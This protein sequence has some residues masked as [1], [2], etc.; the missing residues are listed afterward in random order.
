MNISTG[1]PHILLFERDQQLATL[2][3]SELQL[4]GYSC[5]TARTAVEVFDAIARHSI[6]LVLV[7]LAQAATARREFWVALDAQRRDHKVQVLTFL[8]ANLASYGPRDV[9]D[10]PQNTMADIEIDGMAGVMQMVDAIRSRVPSGSSETGLSTM[11]RV[12]KIATT[13]PT[14]T[15]SY[16]AA[17]S[18]PPSTPSS[19]TRNEGG[20]LHT[21]FYSDQN[22]HIIPS[23]SALSAL[24]Q[25]PTNT[26]SIPVQPATTNP[27]HIEP[28]PIQSPATGMGLT[29]EESYSEKIRAVLNP[30]QRSAGQ[31]SLGENSYVTQQ[32]YQETQSSNTTPSM[33]APSDSALQQLANGQFRTDTSNESGL[34]QLSRMLQ[35]FRAPAH[36]EPP[37]TPPPSPVP[38]MPAPIPTTPTTVTPEPTINTHSHNNKPTTSGNIDYQI[39]DPLPPTADKFAQP[40]P[41]D[42]LP[43]SLPYEETRSSSPVHTII[44]REEHL[45][46][47]D[48]PSHTDQLQQPSGPI[49]A[50]IPSSPRTTY[51]NL[52]EPAGVQP[53]RASP[54]QDMPIER[55]PASHTQ[56][57]G[58]RRSSV[59]THLH[60]SQ[61]SNTPSQVTTNPTPLASIASPMPPTTAAPAQT[62]TQTP[63]AQTP[64]TP[65]QTA[66]QSQPAEVNTQLQSEE[67]KGM[68]KTVLEKKAE[69]ELNSKK[70]NPAPSP[71]Q[72][73]KQ[74]QQPENW[75]QE[76]QRTSIEE[77]MS[78]NSAMLLDIVQSLPP[79]PELSA[80][81]QG[82]QP[83][84]LNGRAT[85][86]LNQ[87]LLD[88]HL[89]P[90]DRLEVAQNIQRMLRG[91]DLNY[92]LGEILL[93]FK[94]LTPDQ[95][96]A[97]GLVSYGLINTTQIS[98]LGRIRQ[99]LHALGLEYDLE[100]LLILFRILTPEQLRE[101]R[102]SMQS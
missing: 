57:D 93:M 64:A 86:S 33:P 22:A 99:E 24:S 6:R 63:P 29:E 14:N 23:K 75:S 18:T 17:P 88:G 82:V 96:L 41:F 65:K 90:Q 68:L 4:A 70:E 38:T 1:G 59:Q 34:A 67:L 101:V 12:P 92:Q 66:H 26:G 95:L 80:Q 84:V 49:K 53:L 10:R 47:I 3:L 25:P 27:A 100:N 7:N 13:P 19:S 35:G 15:G 74:P 94:L 73:Q 31:F 89:V 16:P 43:P 42:T 62:Q 79:M 28:Y 9:E 51:S 56:N 98:A 8:C 69:F 50:Y 54:I 85:R 40:S 71:A 102:S 2:V 76:K 45:S 60:Y 77:S 44:E 20:L 30:G 11:P 5:H 72:P 87:V 21:T 37:T 78:T 97:A 36:E 91:V 81:Q 55:T 58:T 39:V 52:N 46:N 32:N 48:I 61:Q 83:Q